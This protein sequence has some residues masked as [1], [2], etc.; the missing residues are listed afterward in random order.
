VNRCHINGCVRDVHHLPAYACDTCVVRILRHLREI[1]IYTSIIR[2]TKQPGRGND[3]T[4]RAPGY[5]SRSPAN[6]TKLAAD[7]YRT[8][9]TGDGPDDQDDVMS[10]VGT[11]HG[12]NLALRDELGILDTTRGVDLGREFGWLRAHIA[13][14]AEH[15][16]VAD[17]ADNIAELHAQTR[18]LAGDGPPPPVGQCLRD[19]CDG[20]VYPALID[21]PQHPRTGRIDGGR[22]N[23]CGYAYDWNDLVA[24][25]RHRL[26]GSR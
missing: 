24:V 8:R 1:E 10:I 5:G 19:G 18:R 21:D 14:C 17:L 13:W 7:D 12:I 22:C 20:D 23:T 15:P 6:D 3:G 26:E 16:W 2:T 11:I 9:S 4:R 25:H